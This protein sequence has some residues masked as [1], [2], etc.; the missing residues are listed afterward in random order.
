MPGLSP[1]AN[2]HSV[3]VNPSRGLSFSAMGTTRNS[4]S[5]RIEGASPAINNDANGRLNE[6]GPGYFGK[7]GIPLIAGREFTEA[8]NLAGPKVAIVSQQFVK[9]FLEACAASGERG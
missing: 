5:V 8:D 6:V 1:P 2:N 4:N 3:A 7:M 9:A